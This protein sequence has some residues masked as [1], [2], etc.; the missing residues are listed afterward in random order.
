M[1]PI[2]KEIFI[3]L[4]HLLED[5]SDCYIIEKVLEGVS[6]MGK[7]IV[8]SL[9][10]MGNISRERMGFLWQDQST[11]EFMKWIRQ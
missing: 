7:L 6:N 9:S 1:K 11:E 5:L 8:L 10:R 2:G 4:F 3:Y